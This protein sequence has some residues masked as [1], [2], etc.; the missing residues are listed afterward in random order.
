MHALRLHRE[1]M[2][3]FEDNIKLRAALEEIAA[4]S[5]EAFNPLREIAR[6]A[7]RQ[8]GGEMS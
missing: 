4:D 1:K 6:K 2:E 3:Y 8:R 7:L 5:V